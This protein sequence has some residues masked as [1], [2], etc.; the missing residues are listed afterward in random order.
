MAPSAPLWAPRQA[1][2]PSLM[3]MTDANGCAILL[4]AASA[5]RRPRPARPI[6][7]LH[8]REILAH[9]SGL[10]GCRFSSLHDGPPGVLK[11]DPRR[12]GPRVRCTEYPAVFVLDPGPAPGSAAINS[13]I[14]G[15]FCSHGKL[16]PRFRSGSPQSFLGVHM[17]SYK[18]F[19][20][21][22]RDCRSRINTDGPRCFLSHDCRAAH[23]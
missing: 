18:G 2:R 21:R 19:A 23:L 13:Q 5:P 20:S 4:R 14:R 12:G 15:T 22:V 7:A 9:Q 8:P 16:T 3:K 10:C 6:P 1:A 17:K 11:A